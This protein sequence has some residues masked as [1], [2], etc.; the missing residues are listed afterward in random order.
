M[1]D[2]VPARDRRERE[3]EGAR[4]D[5]EKMRVSGRDQGV[6]LYRAVRRASTANAVRRNTTSIAASPR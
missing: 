3:P 6:G 4:A 1:I 2:P 5:D